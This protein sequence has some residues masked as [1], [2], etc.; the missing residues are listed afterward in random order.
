MQRTTS[1]IQIRVV[2][3]P[4]CVCMLVRIGKEDGRNGLHVSLFVFCP[5]SLWRCLL[6][7]DTS[8][9]GRKDTRTRH[10]A[11]KEGGEQGCSQTNK[12][13]TQNPLRTGCKTADDGKKECV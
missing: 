12:T 3:F 2:C 8:S 11:E 7:V 10:R 9:A 6:T 4:D 13:I 5:K 1:W